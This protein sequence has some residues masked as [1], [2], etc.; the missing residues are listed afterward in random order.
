MMAQ[1]KGCKIKLK[2]FSKKFYISRDVYCPTCYPTYLEEENRKIAEQNKSLEIAKIKENEIRII[3]ELNSLKISKEKEH[4]AFEVYKTIS[5]KIEE[6]IRTLI[7]VAFEH[8]QDTLFI[9]FFASVKLNSSNDVISL[10]NKYKQLLSLAGRG[11]GRQVIINEFNAFKTLLFERIEFFNDAKS[12]EVKRDIENIE[13]QRL[14]ELLLGFRSLNSVLEDD[15]HNYLSQEQLQSLKRG[16]FSYEDMLLFIFNDYCDECKKL[17]GK[18]ISKKRND[19]IEY[20]IY[21]FDMNSDICESDNEQLAN[22]INQYLSNRNLDQKQ[23][24][25]SI[26]CDI[27]TTNNFDKYSLSKLR[28]RYDSMMT[29]VQ[30][31]KQSKQSLNAIN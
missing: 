1:C 14:N 27:E 22:F 23:A 30:S 17:S 25:E 20:D 10:L 15:F 11:F 26:Y 24:I 18:F 5:A 12:R 28:E 9:F 16:D 29:D 19:Q 13:P 4:R 6:Q 31:K 3:N 21:H 8:D 2:I 7:D